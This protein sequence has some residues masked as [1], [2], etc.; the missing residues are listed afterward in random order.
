MTGTALK[1]NR[2]SLELLER[3]V[4]ACLRLVPALRDGARRV[5]A[6]ASQMQHEY[7][8]H[9]LVAPAGPAVVLG[10]VARFCGSKND[11]H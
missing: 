3:G 1:T 7:R 8:L 5:Q 11:G 10:V 6:R 9:V 4:I 2:R